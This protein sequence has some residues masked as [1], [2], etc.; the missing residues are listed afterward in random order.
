MSTKKKAQIDFQTTFEN[1]EKMF[2]D[3][4]VELERE[5]PFQLL[6]AVLLSAQATDK[7]V[8]KAT[9]NFFKHIKTPQDIL[10]HCQDAK[11][12][13]CRWLQN[14][15]KTIGLYKSKAKNILKL[16]KILAEISSQGKQALKKYCQST[17]CKEIYTTYGYI[18][19][20]KLEELTK[21]P[22]VGMKT[23]KVILNVLY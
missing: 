19:P 17:K 16:S 9:K 21:L 22:G 11:D 5:T 23:A 14:Q 13:E 8:N 3:A 10:N 20:D 12:D 1:L 15:I 18:I 4:R 6:L 2:P 7:Q